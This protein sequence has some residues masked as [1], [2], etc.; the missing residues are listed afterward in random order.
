MENKKTETI[1]EYKISKKPKKT[2][3]LKPITNEIVCKVE[4]N[5]ILYI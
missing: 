5:V 4:R 1:T 3:K 2:K